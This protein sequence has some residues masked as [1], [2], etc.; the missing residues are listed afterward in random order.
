MCEIKVF[1]KNVDE[2]DKVRSLNVTLVV[3]DTF[4]QCNVWNK[5]LS[6]ISTGD[7]LNISIEKTG[8]V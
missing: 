2:T 6:L 5:I 7:L 3:G 8:V 1:S 4:P